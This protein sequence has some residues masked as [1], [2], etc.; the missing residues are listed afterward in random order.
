[1]DSDSIEERIGSLEEEDVEQLNRI[2][3]NLE[4]VA[5]TAVTTEQ[6]EKAKSDLKA[7]LIWKFVIYSLGAVG[8]IIAVIAVVVGVLAYL[9]QQSPPAA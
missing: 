5:E 8:L 4:T 7:E 2:I 1:M 3:E 9:G 6:L